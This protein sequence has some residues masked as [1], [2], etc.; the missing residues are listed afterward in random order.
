MRPAG[1]IGRV[2]PEPEY[3]AP[4][5]RTVLRGAAGLGLALT[6][7][8]AVAACSAGPSERAQAAQAL[9]PL[10]VAANLQQQQAQQLAPRETDYTKALT[11]V[12]TERGEHAQALLDEI[13]RLNASTAA[14]VPSASAATPLDLDGLRGALEAAAKQAATTAADAGGFRAGLLASISASCTTLRE[15]QLP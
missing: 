13:N 3:R 5:R 11:Q 9:V 14:E 7:G 10:V 15:V 12:A 1:R 4:S 2:S 6:A 8:S